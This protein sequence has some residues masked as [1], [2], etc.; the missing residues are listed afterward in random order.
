M[1]PWP[2][3]LDQQLEPVLRPFFYLPFEH[4]ER[5]QDQDRCVALCQAHRDATGDEDTLK[6]AVL[7]RDIICR[8]GRFPH[9]NAALGRASTAAEQ[10]FLD[11][12]GFAG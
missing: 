12:G 11:A 9:R 1:Q 10:A 8:F 3:D 7:H 6:W 4:S 5:L 2:R